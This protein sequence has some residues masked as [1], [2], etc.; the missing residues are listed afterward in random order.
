M[1]KRILSQDGCARALAFHTRMVF[2][3]QLPQEPN[4]QNSDA[5][6]QDDQVYLNIF[7]HPASPP[8]PPSSPV[9]TPGLLS[10]PS[11]AALG[12]IATMSG[13]SVSGS[14]STANASEDS[15]PIRALQGMD[16]T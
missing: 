15:L 13:G 9:I 8:V 5:P 7:A 4:E 10:P 3:N 16:N 1:Y 11:A 2:P 14:S 12:P 6:T